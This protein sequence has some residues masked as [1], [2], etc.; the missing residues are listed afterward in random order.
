M[1]DLD[2]ANS[3]AQEWVESM[4]G[5]EAIRHDHGSDLS[6]LMQALDDAGLL[7]AELPRPDSHDEHGWP[8]WGNTE[9]KTYFSKHPCKGIPYIS[10]PLSPWMD[11]ESVRK[12]AYRLLAA[13]EWLDEWDKEHAEK[14]Q[15]NE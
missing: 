10:T 11:A 5:L 6:G 4:G 14:E 15:G 8:Q 2:K 1:S 3:V 9:Y 13:A 7:A 12:E